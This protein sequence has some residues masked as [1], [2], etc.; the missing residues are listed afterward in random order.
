MSAEEMYQ[1]DAYCYKAWV[2]VQEI[3]DKEYDKNHQFGLIIRLVAGYHYHWL[4][5]N[6]TFFTTERFWNV[7]EDYRGRP[8]L[9]F[10]YRNLPMKNEDIDWDIVAKDYHNY[11]LGPFDPKMT[12]PSAGNKNARRN[13]LLDELDKMLSAKK[14][15]EEGSRIIDFGCGPGNLIRFLDP[16]KISV[17]TCVDKNETALA[18]AE[19]VGKER[20]I[21]IRKKKCNIKDYQSTEKY[22]IA[23]SVNS[24]LPPKRSDIPLMLESITK[25]LNSNGRF[26]AILPSYDTTEYLRNLWKNYYR[27]TRKYNLEHVERIAKSFQETKKMDE[28]NRSYADDCRIS[29]CYHDEETIT[30]EFKAAGLEIIGKPEKIHYPWELTKRFDYGHFPDAPEEIW[31]W[32]VVARVRA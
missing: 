32:F 30:Q 7:I 11:I 13:K 14:K 17:L 12:E 29:Q 31:D 15:P 25:A 6:P 24:I 4:E 8:D 5:R 27:K 3:I 21:H 26:I 16:S 22:D 19:Q 1:Y 23:I 18:I 20:G 28:K 10:G 2:H 9:I